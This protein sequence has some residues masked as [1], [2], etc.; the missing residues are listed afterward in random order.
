MLAPVLHVNGQH[1][2]A[3]AAA[4]P[5]VQ[6]HVR[7]LGNNVFGFEASELDTMANFTSKGRPLLDGDS[8]DGVEGLNQSADSDFNDLIVTLNFS[9][10]QMI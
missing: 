10:Q 6:S 1:Y 8:S 7:M 3:F 2:F 5:N 4:N 9:L